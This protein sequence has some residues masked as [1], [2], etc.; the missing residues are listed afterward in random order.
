MNW[1]LEVLQKK[2]A[3]FDGRAHRE[4]FWMFALINLLVSIGV[5]VVG[6]LLHLY[7]LRL[8]YSLAVL[9]PAMAVGA[10]RLH[11]TSRSAWWLLIGL[12]PLVGQIVLI[13]FFVQDSD[14]S[15]NLY[16]PNPRAAAPPPG[17]AGVPPPSA[18]P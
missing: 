17:A 14:P 11:D 5:A 12:I 18:Q 4:E 7:V 16:G 3:Q 10:R 1:Y 15:Q 2:Y 8:L 9:V 6:Y 13:V